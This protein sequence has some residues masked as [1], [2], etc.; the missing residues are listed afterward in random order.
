MRS[1]IFSSIALCILLAFGSLALAG[2]GGSDKSDEATEAPAAEQPAEQSAS[3]DDAAAADDAEQDD[4]Y[5]DDLPVV[6]E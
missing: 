5:G 6:N 4:C 3:P 2:C 1:R